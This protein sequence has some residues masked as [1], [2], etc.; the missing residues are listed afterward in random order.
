MFPTQGAE[1]MSSRTKDSKTDHYN[2]IAHHYSHPHKHLEY[3]IINLC[4]AGRAKCTVSLQHYTEGAH[5]R[6]QRE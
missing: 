3:V 6:Q 5:A 2:Y 4:S 1:D